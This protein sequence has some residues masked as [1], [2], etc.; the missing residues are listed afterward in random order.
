MK[1]N[2]WVGRTGV[3][4]GTLDSLMIACESAEL[5]LGVT[6]ASPATN[7]YDCPQI[8]YLWQGRATFLH[9]ATGIDYAQEG[10]PREY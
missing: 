4:S 5:Q 1:E 2:K 7:L 10:E 8:P 6:A 3:S 9:E